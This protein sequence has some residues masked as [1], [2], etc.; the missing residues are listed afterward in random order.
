M[1]VDRNTIRRP[2]DARL[3]RRGSFAVEMLVLLPIFITL[4]LAVVEISLMLAVSHQ[5]AAASREGARVAAQGGDEQEVDDAVQRSLGN[6]K[7]S[8]ASIDAI[9]TDNQGRPLHAGDPVVVEVSIPA[10]D[11]IPDVLRFIGWTL[12]DETL[13]GRTIMRKE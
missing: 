3:P 1:R 13:R 12:Q 4:V 9:L 6:G 5:L 7:L 8:Q 2:G 11:A 10:T